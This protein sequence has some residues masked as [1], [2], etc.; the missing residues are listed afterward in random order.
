M[1]KTIPSPLVE[2]RAKF[3][4][5][6]PGATFVNFPYRNPY[7]GTL[8]PRINPKIGNIWLSDKWN[9]Y[10]WVDTY[11]IIQ[12]EKE[13]GMYER[14]EESPMQMAYQHNGSDIN[15]ILCRAEAYYE[16]V[17]RWKPKNEALRAQRQQQQLSENNRNIQKKQK[18]ID[19]FIAMCDNILKSGEAEAIL[20]RF[21]NVPDRFGHKDSTL[22]FIPN[23]LYCAKGI[24]RFAD[25]NEIRF[26]DAEEI[27]EEYAVALIV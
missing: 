12:N 5:E 10:L 26:E 23:R 27:L 2:L 21:I 24:K 11:E 25:T 1:S 22:D 13:L 14:L 9:A 4:Q 17:C 16:T 15:E 18:Y 7:D 8:I 6:N 19:N 20:A 3:I